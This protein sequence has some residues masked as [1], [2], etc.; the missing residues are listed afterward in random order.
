LN[1][2]SRAVRDAALSTVAPW[3]SPP[4]APGTRRGRY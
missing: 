3:S 4:G 2:W 1:R